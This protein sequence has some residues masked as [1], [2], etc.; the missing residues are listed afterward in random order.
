[1][2]GFSSSPFAETIQ[3][4]AAHKTIQLYTISISE[5]R[6]IFTDQMPTYL[7]FKSKCVPLRRRDSQHVV[8]QSLGMTRQYLKHR[9]KILKYTLDVLC[10]WQY[11][12]WRWHIT[13][14]FT[15]FI[16][17]YTAK[18]AYTCVFMTCTSYCLSDTLM[19]SWTVRIYAYA[20]VCISGITPTEWG[21]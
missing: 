16:V 17:F 2:F 3:R 21:R 13:L 11:Y 6:T 7:V 14:F 1:M 12:V 19:N 4:C 18:T 20:Y 8:W 9:R 5:I 10:R 15:M